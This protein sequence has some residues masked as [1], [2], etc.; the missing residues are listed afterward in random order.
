MVLVSAF[1]GNGEYLQGS[2]FITKDGRGNVGV[3][4][5]F[6]LIN[7]IIKNQ[8][9]NFIFVHNKAGQ[10]FAVHAVTSIS[11]QDNLI[12][13]TVRGDITKQGA[14]PPL[15]PNFRTVLYK[16]DQLFYTSLPLAYGHSWFKAHKVQQAVALPPDRT[17]FLIN[18]P[19]Q[20]VIQSSLG[21]SLILN[22]EGD[23]ISIAFI[24]SGHTLF[25]V[26]Y[27]NFKQFLN[28]SKDRSR[29]IRGHIVTAK[30]LLYEESLYG[31]P[32]AKHALA[33]HSGESLNGFRAFMQSIGELPA[34]A[35]VNNI[36]QALLKSSVKWEPELYFKHLVLNK[37]LKSEEIKK[38]LAALAN[39]ESMNFLIEKGHPHFE[40]IL[41]WIYFLQGEEQKA[42]SL[43]NKSAQKGYLLS[44]Q[45]KKILKASSS[46]TSSPNTTSK[47]CKTAF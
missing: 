31:N 41:S 15:M 47:T 37:N 18:R 20:N 35:R 2:G 17:D 27:R 7:E 43:L 36:W 26:P 4:T 46:K 24:G 5:S 3:L 14:F 42:L 8:S 45:R 13:L 9:G 40:Y 23:V 11:A 32:K 6:H 44:I 21:G 16:G 33:L 34:A 25:G 1:E 19:A 30:K 29:F 22:Q 10:A 28:L 38:Q 39:S 12:F